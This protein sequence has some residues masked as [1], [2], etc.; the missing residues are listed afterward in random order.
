MTAPVIHGEETYAEKW[1]I[2]VEQGYTTLHCLDRVLLG[3]VAS[4]VLE[5]NSGSV[6]DILKDTGETRNCRRAKLPLVSPG[7][8]QQDSG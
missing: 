7:A 2:V 8:A 4:F 5:S 3:S 6:G 1:G